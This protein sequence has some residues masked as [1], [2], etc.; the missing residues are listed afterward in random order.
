MIK[1]FLKHKEVTDFVVLHL[2]VVLALSGFGLF[3]MLAYLKSDIVIA[4]M[5]AVALV[6]LSIA[7]IPA[8]RMHKMAQRVAPK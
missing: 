6:V 1:F 3:A 4:A 5:L 2:M 8:Y 7:L